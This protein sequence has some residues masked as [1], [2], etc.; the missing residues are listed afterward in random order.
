MSGYHFDCPACIR[1]HAVHPDDLQ[2]HATRPDRICQ[3]CFDE[4]C[5]S[6]MPEET[7][8]ECDDADY[9]FDDDPDIFGD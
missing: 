6:C 1:V 5:V 9:D 8:A 4:G 7:C 2:H 3:F